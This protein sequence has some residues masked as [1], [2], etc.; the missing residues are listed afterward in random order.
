MKLTLLQAAM[1][2]GSLLLYVGLPVFVLITAPKF[3]AI[4]MRAIWRAQ[5]K[6]A[7]IENRSPFYKDPIV[8]FPV[9]VLSLVVLS[10]LYYSLLL[11]FSLAM[12][13]A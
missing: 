2:A 8:Y 3:I 13:W 1:L 7:F 5:G 12:G 11:L 4:V 9:L 10:C 6:K